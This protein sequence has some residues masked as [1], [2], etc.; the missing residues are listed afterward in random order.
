MKLF[1]LVDSD[2]EWWIEHASVQRCFSRRVTLS[3]I[4]AVTEEIF[5]VGANPPQL[6]PFAEYSACPAHSGILALSQTRWTVRRDHQEESRA[7]GKKEGKEKEEESEEEGEREEG[8]SDPRH[9]GRI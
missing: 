1:K 6:Q 2:V 7:E 9:S 5:Q 4:L 8:N 3:R